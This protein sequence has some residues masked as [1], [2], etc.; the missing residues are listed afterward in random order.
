MQRDERTYLNDIVE[1]CTAIQRAVTGLDLAAYRAD[2]LL[3]SA[4]EREFIIIGLRSDHTRSPD[5]RL[6]HS[7]HA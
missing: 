6:P 1:A 4:V 2:R 5:R 7:A 3:R